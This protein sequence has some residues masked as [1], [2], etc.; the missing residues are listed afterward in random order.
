MKAVQFDHYGDPSVLEVVDAAT[1]VPAAGEV[2][3]R[4]RAA[5]VNLIDLKR[6]RGDLAQVFPDTFP[7]TPGTD[8]SGVVEAV[9]EVVTGASVGD[10]V[11]GG[12]TSGAYAEQC[13]LHPWFAK[14]A[15]LSWEVAAALPTIA[16]TA[17][18]CVG[19]L[20][21]SPGEVVLIFGAAGGVGML[22]T[23]LAMARGVAVI[24]VVTSPEQG[25]MIERFGATAV[26]AGPDLVERLRTSGVDRVDAV[27]DTSGAGV[28]EVAVTLAG[29][30][31][32][33]VTIADMG[34]ASLG[35]RFSG[36]DAV[37]AYDQIPAV[38]AGVATGSLWVPA[39]TVR[40]LAD[41]VS[42]HE[43]IEARRLSGKVVLVSASTDDGS[44]R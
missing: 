27:L 6:R 19:E 29:G 4:V 34:A 38:A 37:R 7:V 43:D 1:P 14:P 36:G 25:E 26:S 3:I 16:E 30:P 31:E 9:G 44:M 22:A 33:V 17:A 10:E 35:V 11:F 41:A 23:Q 39:P 21:P 8:A 20:V 15:G 2:L 42:V 40:D 18:R 32:R 5:A 12:A 13:T 28:L 24:G